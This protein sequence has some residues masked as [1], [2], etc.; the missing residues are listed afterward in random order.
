MQ[1]AAQQ[2]ASMNVLSQH[3]QPP[4]P[5]VFVTHGPPQDGSQK[6]LASRKRVKVE[7]GGACACA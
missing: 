6:H 7:E 3:Q 2:Q 1:P 5:P 4:Y